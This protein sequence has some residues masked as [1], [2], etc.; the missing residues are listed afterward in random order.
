ME[1]LSLKGRILLFRKRRKKLKLKEKGAMAKAIE[2]AKSLI[3]IIDNSIIAEKT[4][5]SLTEIEY[6]SKDKE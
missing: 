4:G 2:I 1:R 6:L 3:G 5:L